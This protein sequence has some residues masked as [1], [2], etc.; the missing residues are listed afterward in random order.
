MGANGRGQKATV[1][2]TRRLARRLVLEP[3]SRSESAVENM[4]NFQPVRSRLMVEIDERFI[5]G[6]YSIS[7]DTITV[8][9]RRLTKSRKLDGWTPKILA[10][11][12]LRELAQE[13]N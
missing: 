7:E 4:E 9:F 8:T 1:K 13:T 12:M 3:S 2:K 11:E 10:A 6:S 5:F